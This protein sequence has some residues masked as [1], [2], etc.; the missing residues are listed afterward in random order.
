MTFGPRKGGPQ[1][2]YARAMQLIISVMKAQKV[3]RLACIT[4]ALIGEQYT[5]R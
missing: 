1:V 3:G 4:V 2:F 5:S